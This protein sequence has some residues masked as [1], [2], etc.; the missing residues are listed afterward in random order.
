MVTVH[1]LRHPANGDAAVDADAPDERWR[2][3]ASCRG[4][5]PVLFFPE[6]DEGPG[7]ERAQEVCA[8][9]PVREQCLQSALANKEGYGIWG[10]TTPRERRRLAR[11][12]RRS[13]RTA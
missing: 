1:Q 5:D 13:R 10:G 3:R 4:L 12:S 8:T 6:D 7:A 9:C 2:A 11:R